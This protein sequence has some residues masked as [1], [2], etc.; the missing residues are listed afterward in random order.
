MNNNNEKHNG[1]TN[2]ETWRVN[3]EIFAGFIAEDWEEVTG[4]WCKDY[5][6]DI[7]CEGQEESFA[8]DY[9]LA[10]LGPVNWYEIAESINHE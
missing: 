6:A 2:Y 7:V 9:A 8:L 10:F 1:W 5:A 3:L 4:E